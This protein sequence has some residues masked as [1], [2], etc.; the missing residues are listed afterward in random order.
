MKSKKF[1]GMVNFYRRFLSNAVDTQQKLH[2]YLKGNKKRDKV[3]IQ[4]TDEHLMIA[5]GGCWLIDATILAHPFS[6]SNLSI[7]VDASQFTI[8]AVV[9]QKNRHVMATIGIF[10]EKI[11]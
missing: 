11:R 5:N 2:V 6:S 4:W 9:Q 7:M 3:I 1:L 10:F 8:G